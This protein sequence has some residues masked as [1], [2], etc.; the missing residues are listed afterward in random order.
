M[1]PKKTEV[2]V[3]DTNV[4]K[5]GRAGN[6]LRMGILGLPNVGKSSLFNLLTEQSIPAENYP[7]CTIDPNEA[8]CAL[9]DARYEHLTSI[10]KPANSYPAYLQVVD[11]AGLV[12]GASEGK[13]LGNDF[14]SHIQ[15]VDGL[16]HVVRAFEDPDITH[17]DDTVD[18]VRDLE[19]IQMELCLKDLQYVKRAIEDEE[20]DVKKSRGMKLSA[21]FI[22]T[23]ARVQGML[24]S[25]QPIRDGVWS[26]T[27]VDMI[28]NKCP[29]LITT[30]PIIY[31][32]NMSAADFANKK[33]KWLPKIHAWV[34]EHGGGSMIPLSVDW[35]ANYFKA[36]DD[37]DAQ[38]A[39]VDAH[40]GATSVLP[41]VVQTG[42]SNLDL[43]HYFTAGEKEVRC[44][45]LQR[46]Q[47][48]PAAAGLIHSDFER[49]F[50]KAEV[51]A[52]ADFKS[53]NT[54]SKGLSEAK[55]AGKFR[56]EGKTYIVQV[57]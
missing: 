13:G 37:K 6:T 5:F 10:W 22:E 1:P 25:N 43:V 44:W 2:N 4:A 30:K 20:R 12:R 50:I 57:C 24:E 32:V 8:R 7:F 35:E 16:F 46:G 47:C 19:T 11:I 18:P 49:G 3:G 27:E 23:L 14:L 15:R 34:K 38:A 17:V 42:Y 40:A 29:Q 45:T 33:N 48:A 41:K 21:L 54:G 36:K 31:L 52:Y 26:T 56:I 28:R 51:V 53:L 55:A 9:P 39:F